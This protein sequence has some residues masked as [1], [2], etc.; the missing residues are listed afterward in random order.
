MR[1]KSTKIW[2]VINKYQPLVV[3]GSGLWLSMLLMLLLPASAQAAITYVQQN[4]T[5]TKNLAFPYDT[6]TV[7]I[8]N[9]PTIGNTIIVSTGINVSSGSSV[10]CSD[11][12]N[13]YSIDRSLTT[14][15]AFPYR[16]VI[17]C[18]AKIATVPGS[19]TVTHDY[20]NES[21]IDVHEFSGIADAPRVDR[22]NVNSGSGTT[23]TS[24]STS[25]SSE[26]N[27]LVFGAL[28]VNGP[29]SDSFI[30]DS[31]FPGGPF[32]TSI[33]NVTINTQ[34]WI[35]TG[36]ASTYA[37]APTLGTSRLW[38]GAVVTY[39]AAAVAGINIVGTCQQQ[40]ETT[41]CA[42]GGTVRI[43]IN[44]DLQGQSTATSAGTWTIAG[45]AAPASGDVIT[46]FIDGVV[47]IREAVAVT[48]YDGVGDITGVELIEE[49]LTIG[50]DDNQIVS[51]ADLS[52]YD[53]SVSIDE[54]VFHEVNGSN[55][56][57]VDTTGALTAEEL[58][59]K[60]GNTFQPGAGNVTT[61]DLEI[62]GT[63][64][65]GSSNITLDGSWDNNAVFTA[66]AS[67]VN[68][69][70]GSGTETIDSTTA[71]GPDF[72]NIHFNDAGGSGTFQLESALNVSNNLTITD[73]ILDAN[74]GSSYA[75]NVGND[76]LQPGGRV[77]ARS[78]T[79]TV[80]RHFTADGSESDTGYNSATL[81]MSGAGIL[82]YNNVASYWANG[83]RDVTVGQSGSTT[84]LADTQFCV[85]NVLTVGSGTLL[86]SGPLSDLYLRGVPNPL[87][88]NVNSIINISTLYFHNNISQN[89]PPL[90][91]G[92]DSDINLSRNNASVTQTGAITINSGSHLLLD[93]DTFA[94]RTVTYITNGFNL[95]VAGNIQ[96]GEGDD[97][98]LKTLNGTNSNITVGGDFEI[99][100]V[101]TGTQQALFI[102]SNSTV[103]LNG[104]A[105]QVITSS[106]SSFNHLTINNT[107][108]VG[109]DDVIIA[110]ALDIN[111]D[112]TVTNGQLDLESNN[113]AVNTAGNVTIQT[114]GAVWVGARTADWTFD[115][116]SLLSDSSSGAAQDLQDV[117]VDGTSLTLA[118]NTRVETMSVTTG[119]LNL[120]AAG[121]VLAIDGTGTPLSSLAT[122]VA[123]TSTV[124]YTGSGSAT[125]VATLPYSSLQFAP[126]AAT[127]YSLT[128]HLTGGNAMTG[129]LT[130]GDNAT[131][132]TTAINN[133]NITMSGNYDQSSTTSLVEANSSTI[134]VGGDFTADGSVSENGYNSA[135]LVMDGVGLLTYNNVSAPWDNGF[136]GLTVGLDG[137]TTTMANLWLCVLDVLTVGSGTLV[138]SG[139][140]SDIFLKGEPYPLSF[141]AG[142]TVNIDALNFHDNLTQNIPPLVN[143]YDSDIYLT[144]TN[145]NVVQT[146]AIT[147]NAGNDLILNGDNFVNRAVTYN[148]NGFDLNVAGNIQIGAGD[149]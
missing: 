76:F 80:A 41:N 63:F 111:G 112:L 99:R 104:T 145:A 35:T 51:N 38:V 40:D 31:N 9:A 21:A 72:Y 102:A 48:R 144:R 148:T 97:T 24:N 138:G 12:V 119:T 123:G 59:I 140:S 118:S 29:S 121:Y 18:S 106:G 116:T 55:N 8:S 149:D 7:T 79:L 30:A 34:Y 124:N 36:A 92:Y 5:V 70:S 125:N 3:F 137:N 73:G 88:F 10:A 127:T 90:V 120:G 50:S 113:P 53:N 19:I 82:T 85:L 67:T 14:F 105:D 109:N 101:G 131:L 46:V 114:N 147:I 66:G 83:F 11:G 84:T 126:T 136:S 87:S 75:I 110:D 74:N 78:S 16:E 37:Y 139:T 27:V 141:D 143:G 45:V 56:L 23:P 146:G 44:G 100:D 103:T 26:S 58:Y 71:T 4:G 13:T 68:F 77:L 96:I 52:Q 108:T 95:N 130:V 132:E 81:V 117:V 28:E 25:S 98:G 62:N 86:G 2:G 32:R 15:P 6:T 39:K 135:V 94:D 61:H 22:S 142:S 57:T 43:A 69:T 107:G 115:G 47:D 54:D 60:S 42:D 89:I 128:G 65:A 64:I 129:H 133:Y 93:G 134:T 1:D 49:H 91:N 122:F 17:V 33:N 20:A